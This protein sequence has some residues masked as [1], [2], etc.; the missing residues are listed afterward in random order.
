MDCPLSDTF[1][2]LSLLTRTSSSAPTSLFFSGAEVSASLLLTFHVRVFWNSVFRLM[3]DVLS[4]T[5]PLRLSHE[6]DS[7]TSD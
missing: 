5:L 7:S 6:D 2:D 4:G 3:L 1:N